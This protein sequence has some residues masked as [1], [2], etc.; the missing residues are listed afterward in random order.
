MVYISHKSFNSHYITCHKI[1]NGLNLSRTVSKWHA[2]IFSALWPNS[3]PVF[4]IV[5]L[6]VWEPAWPACS[7]NKKL[8]YD[9]GDPVVQ[10]SQCNSVIFPI[11]SSIIIFQILND[12]RHICYRN[13]YF[14]L[15]CEKSGDAPVASSGGFVFFTVGKQYQ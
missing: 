14:Q 4:S 11:F 5:C 7:S 2:F 13:R 6:I 3:V 8:Y 12:R 9:W 1:W 15:F 10:N